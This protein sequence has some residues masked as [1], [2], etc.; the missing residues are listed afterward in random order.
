[1]DALRITFINVGYGESILLKCPSAVRTG[2]TFVMVIDGGSSE[3][4]EYIPTKSGR[5][6]LTEYLN[7]V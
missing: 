6:R 5:I 2:E 1:M 3:P 4:A 7:K